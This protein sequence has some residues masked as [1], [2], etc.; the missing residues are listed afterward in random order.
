MKD[1]E[2]MMKRHP[3]EVG[4]GIDHYAALEFNGADFRVLSIPGQMGSI[5]VNDGG[6]N[7]PGVWV[8]Y[9]DENGIVHSKV[10]PRSGKVHELLQTVED[11]SKHL[12]LDEKVQLCRKEN[13]SS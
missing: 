13:P 4:I 3:Y 7:V 2:S 8:N 10:C 5:D 1:F 6:S 9:V 12:L 11:P